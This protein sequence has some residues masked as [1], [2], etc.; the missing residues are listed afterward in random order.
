[1]LSSFWILRDEDGGLSQF[2]LGRRDSEAEFA[3][4]LEGSNES[5]RSLG[6]LPKRQ[7]NRLSREGDFPSKP[8][9]RGQ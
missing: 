3:Q 9:L 8:H 7:L 4:D 1:M 2:D 6:A 5:W